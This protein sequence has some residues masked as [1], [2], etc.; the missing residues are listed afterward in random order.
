MS[1]SRW[2]I[3]G[4]NGYTGELVARLAAIRGSRPVLAGRNAAAVGTLAGELGL[5]HAVFDLRDPAATRRELAAVD[6]V[7]HCAGPFAATSRPMVDACLATGAHYL[8]VT[9]EHAVFE[10]V[11]SRSAEAEAAGVVLLTGAGF[12]VVPTDCLANL[13]HAALPDATALELAFVAPGGTSRGTAVTGLA[14]S[15]RGGWRRIAGVMVPT[16]IGTPARDVPF[17]SK[18]RRVGAVPWGDLVTAY[19]STGI[20]DITVYTR[21]PAPTLM[22]RLIRFAPVRALAT[23]AVRR[24]PPGPS[25]ETRAATRIEVWGEVRNAAGETRTATLTG[26]NAYDLTADA[27]HRAAEHLL[28]GTGGRTG[29]P[30][31]PGAHTPATAFGPPF[32]RTLTDVEVQGRVPY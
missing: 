32:L 5:D 6:V 12:D 28:S 17:P 14:T 30:V 19:H 26:P 15:A 18:V 9:G 24:Q 8:D 13:L 11:L 20:G 10:A 4:A 31:T 21:V 3:Y 7:A 23:W 22:S 16:P 29:G 25:A 2:M 27:V 1:S